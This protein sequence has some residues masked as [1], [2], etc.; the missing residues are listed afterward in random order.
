MVSPVQ[1]QSFDLVESHFSANPAYQPAEGGVTLQPI[2]YVRGQLIS[3]ESLPEPSEGETIV[4]VDL[5]TER[6]SRS[7][8]EGGTEQF[9]IFLYVGI[10]TVSEAVQDTMPYQ[11][12]TVTL[13]RFSANDVPPASEEEDRSR[14]L[15][16]IRVNGASML[17]GGLRRVIQR[18]TTSHRYP[19]LLLPGI[20]LREVVEWEKAHDAEGPLPA[21][22]SS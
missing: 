22:D 7:E 14:V 17:Y 15:D 3:P 2:F 4:Q 12:E 1:M 19:F 18:L 11:I 10:N 5:S 20:N 8:S 16:I 21:P 6:I 9:D 13:G